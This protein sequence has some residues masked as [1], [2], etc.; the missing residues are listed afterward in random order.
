MSPSSARSLLVSD[1][2]YF[3]MCTLAG[4]C[5]CQA[6]EAWKSPYAASAHQHTLQVHDQLCTKTTGR[7]IEQ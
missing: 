7:L 6:L 4:V 2:V 1:S 3:Y 5:L